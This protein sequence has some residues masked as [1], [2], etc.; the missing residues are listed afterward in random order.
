MIFRTKETAVTVLRP[1]ITP[2]P[3]QLAELQRRFS[4]LSYQPR[5]GFHRDLRQDRQMP[6]PRW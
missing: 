5:N 3:S 6:R 2:D 4:E 1:R